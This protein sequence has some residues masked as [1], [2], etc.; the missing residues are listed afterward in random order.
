MCRR[1]ALVAIAVDFVYSMSSGCKWEIALHESIDKHHA[2]QVLTV[3]PS[4]F[5]CDV[6]GQCNET[7]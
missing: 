5:S 3:A 1:T 2:M 7:R 4:G 6:Y